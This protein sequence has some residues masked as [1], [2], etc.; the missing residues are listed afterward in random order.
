MVLDRAGL[1][2]LG[3]R[4]LEDS[5]ECY[6]GTFNEQE[7]QWQIPAEKT[8]FDFFFSMVIDQYP[9]V[10]YR[11]DLIDANRQ[12]GGLSNLREELQSMDYRDLGEVSATRLDLAQMIY[13]ATPSECLFPPLALVTALPDT[14]DS[15]AVALYNCGILAGMDEKGTFAGDQLLSRAQA[16]AVFA[17]IISPNLRIRPAPEPREASQLCSILVSHGSFGFVDTEYLLDLENGLL[18]SFSAD[19]WAGEAERDPEGENLGFQLC[20]S[21][22]AQLLSDFQTS[23]ALLALLSWNG[24]YVAMAADGHQWGITLTFTDG[25]TREIF[26]S[27]AYPEEWELVYEALK[28]LTGKEILDTHSYAMTWYD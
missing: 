16:A 25:S 6:D 2:R 10:W 18:W 9:A 7:G 13:A 12:F 3:C 19:P 8:T 21:L 26:G 15:A 24:V 28:V 4:S 27:N 5:R 20:E 17:R 23:P 22:E 14:E 11:D 1:I